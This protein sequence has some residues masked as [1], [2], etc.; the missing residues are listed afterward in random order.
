MITHGGQPICKSMTGMWQYPMSLRD[1]YVMSAIGR[2]DERAA[3]AILI[4]Y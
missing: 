4:Y 3:N 1:Q 2:F